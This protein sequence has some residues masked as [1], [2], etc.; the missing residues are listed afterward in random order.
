MKFILKTML[1][2]LVSLSAMADVVNPA[3]VSENTNE[4]DQKVLKDIWK[5][6]FSLGASVY[7]GNQEFTLF[8][9]NSKI[10]AQFPSHTVSIIPKLEYRQTDEE[11]LRKIDVTLN[12]VVD[13]KSLGN[14]QKNW[15]AFIDAR[16]LK[17]DSKG[18]EH[19]TNTLVGI[20]YDFWGEYRGDGEALKLSVAL[21][22]RDQ[23]NIDDSKE[24]F[25]FLSSRIKMVK[26]INK[27]TKF[28]VAAWHIASFKD[29]N[30]DYE[31][32]LEIRYENVL[33]KTTSVEV[34]QESTY[35]N[36]PVEDRVRYNS[37]SKIVFNWKPE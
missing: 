13:M 29:F 9:L 14:L 8:T 30:R 4:T 36:L 20:G 12:D 11:K 16:Y 31:A 19:S 26:P 22:Y 34:K 21:G 18:I 32:S 23:T 28:N 15:G 7:S 24:H 10:S 37:I 5:Y 2:L 27:F 25:P 35:E 6:E 1:L 17:D 33:S 3:T